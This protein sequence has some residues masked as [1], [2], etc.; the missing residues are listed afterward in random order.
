MLTIKLSSI[1][2]AIAHA[3]ELSDD[4]QAELLE[5]LLMPKVYRLWHKLN[6]EHFPDPNV[7]RHP[8]L[9]PT[10]TRDDNEARC[11]AQTWRQYA[12][13]VFNYGLQSYTWNSVRDDYYGHSPSTAWD[14]IRRETTCGFVE[15]LR[16]AHYNLAQGKTVSCYIVQCLDAY[17]IVLDK[18]N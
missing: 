1:T 15:A 14:G 2:K 18:E 12:G 13:Y 10:G 6:S 4:W 11:K 7:T 8:G 5:I 17:K 9:K 16:M 3:R